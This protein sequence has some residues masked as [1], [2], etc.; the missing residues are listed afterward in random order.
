MKGFHAIVY[1]EEKK[2]DKGTETQSM[3]SLYCKIVFLK[4]MVLRC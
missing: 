2:E 4:Q 1:N 3:H